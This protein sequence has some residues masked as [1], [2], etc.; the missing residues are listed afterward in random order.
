MTDVSRQPAYRWVIVFAA[1]LILAISMGAMVNGMSAFIVPMQERYGWT[2]GDAALINFAGILGMAFGGVLAGRVAD[3]IGARPVLVFGVVVLGLCYLAA[4]LLTSLWQYYAL[5]L[6]AGF[7]GAGAIFP[8]V[9]ALVGNWFAV[10][11]GLAIGIVSAGQALGQGG[12]PF[13]SSYLIASY[14]V[15]GALGITGAVMLALMTPAAL[16]MRRAPSRESGAPGDALDADETAIPYNVVI[17]RMSAAVVLCCTCMSVPLMH[18]LPLVQDVIYPAVEDAGGVVFA[19]MLAGI[20]GRVAFGKLADVIGAVPAYMTATAWMTAMVFGFVWLESLTAFY[21]YAIVY[22]F[23]YA[24]VMTGI[25]TSV[26]AL[27]PAERRASAMG[28]IGMFAWFG[29]AIGGYQGGLLYDLTGAYVV[30]YAIAAAAGVVNL[31]IVSTLLRWPR[32]PQ[33]V[34]A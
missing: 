18:L 29:H 17:V 2:R 8:P 34:A 7:F 16:L 31:V 4:S 21:L 20:L 27:T 28:V 15:P 11:A 19:M 30:P 9:M 32:S 6:V 10:G 14:G 33:P 13:A 5:F 23:G 12:V 25:L 3:R 24:G 1:A 22:G 26:R